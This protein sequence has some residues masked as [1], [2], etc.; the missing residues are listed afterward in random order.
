MSELVHG[1]TPASEWIERYSA[2]IRP[3][4]SV[5]DV[6]C[7]AGR[8]MKLLASMGM[9]CVGVD[10]SAQALAHA[11][12]YGEVIE[13]DIE[14]GPWPLAGR[15]FDALVVTNYLWRPLMP[16]LVDSLLDGGFLLYETF[17]V[18]HETVG[19]PSRPEFLLRPGELLEIARQHA[20]QVVA[21]ED[22]WLERPRRRIQRIVASR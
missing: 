7:G 12:A 21:F 22:V 18:G 20:L 3:H 2:L 11:G 14:N 17:A 15:R 8:H 10:R 19:K 4:G 6:A 9:R 13:A 5:L 16:T 1:L